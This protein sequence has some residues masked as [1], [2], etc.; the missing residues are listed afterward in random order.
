[1]AQ[2]VSRVKAIAPWRGT[3]RHLEQVRQ[4]RDVDGEEDDQQWHSQRRPLPQAG[5][6]ETISI[7]IAPVTAM[8]A[9]ARFDEE[10]NINTSG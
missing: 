3:A 5:T 9:A 10:P 2:V 6:T 1:L 7:S 4:S 8:P